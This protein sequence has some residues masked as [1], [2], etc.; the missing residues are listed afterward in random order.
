VRRRSMEEYSGCYDLVME[1]V[2]DATKKFNGLYILNEKKYAALEVICSMVD[3]F[4]SEIEPN[5]VDVS[6]DTNSK[7][8]TF[9]IGCDDLVLEHGSSDLFFAMIRRMDSFSF[10]K[11][12]NGG[13]CI[14]LNLDGLWRRIHG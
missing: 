1:I 5:F 12:K 3:D 4:V 2:D 8:L 6:V 14:A 11:T 13:L 9:D 10:S 7:Q